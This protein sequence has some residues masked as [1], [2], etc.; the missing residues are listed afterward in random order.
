MGS[1]SLLWFSPTGVEPTF[2][3]GRNERPSATG[4]S[5]TFPPSSQIDSEQTR[6]MAVMGKA[7]LKCLEL[8]KTY[9]RQS[10][11]SPTDWRFSANSRAV[12]ERCRNAGPSAR[13]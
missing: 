10:H 7:G 2:C 6:R 11:I 5:A 13:A 3:Y 4:R 8:G 12:P 9:R 1:G